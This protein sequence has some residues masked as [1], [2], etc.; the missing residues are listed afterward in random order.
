MIINNN[1]CNKKSL[2]HLSCGSSSNAGMR[3]SLWDVSFLYSIDVLICLRVVRT[4]LSSSFDIWS[5]KYFPQMMG[6]EPDSIYSVSIVCCNYVDEKQLC[7]VGN[8]TRIELITSELVPP[9]LIMN[10]LVPPPLIIDHRYCCWYRTRLCDGCQG[11]QNQ[12]D[13]GYCCLDAA[14]SRRAVCRRQLG[15]KINVSPVWRPF[16]SIW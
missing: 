11:G 12:Q 8:K 9:L 5:W 6:L 14:I 10:E 16:H 4:P 3:I 2:S 15:Q 7:P 13:E 1:N